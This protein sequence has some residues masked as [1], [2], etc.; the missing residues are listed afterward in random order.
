MEW[1]PIEKDNI[2]NKQSNYSNFSNT[3]ASVY[4]F[5]NAF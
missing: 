5:H 1:I 3:I 4:I 2:Y